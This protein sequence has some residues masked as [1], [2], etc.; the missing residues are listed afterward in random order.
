MAES[1][2]KDAATLHPVVHTPGPWIVHGGPGRLHHY[3][4]VIDS[5]P[6]VDGKVVAN[7]ICHVATTNEDSDANSRLIAAAPDLLAA[8]KRYLDAMDRYGHPDKTDRL[9]RA[10]IEKATGEVV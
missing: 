1:K 8:C 3:L 10:A 2:D 5:I 4:A 7:C 9:M 6:D